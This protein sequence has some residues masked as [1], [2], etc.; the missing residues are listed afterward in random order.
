MSK[1]KALLLVPVIF[2]TGC[3]INEQLTTASRQFINTVGKDY[4]RYVINDPNLTDAEKQDR[5]NNVVSFEQAIQAAENL[6]KGN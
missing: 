6:N 3:S 1:R 2:L 5:F 4:N